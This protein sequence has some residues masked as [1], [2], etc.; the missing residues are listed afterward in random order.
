MLEKETTI[1]TTKNILDIIWQAVAFNS[2][3]EAVNLF[4]FFVKKPNKF[5]ASK[6]IY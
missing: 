5:T 1:Y 6:I 3:L 2:F 4:G